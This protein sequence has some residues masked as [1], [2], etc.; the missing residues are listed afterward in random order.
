MFWV[1][2]VFWGVLDVLGVKSVL[3]VF[4]VFLGVSCVLVCYLSVIVLFEC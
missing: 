4:S 2:L 1:F 3:G